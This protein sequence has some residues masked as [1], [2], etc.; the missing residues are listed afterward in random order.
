MA[1]Q[2]AMRQNN[3]KTTIHAKI[4]SQENRIEFH[5]INDGTH[6]IWIHADFEFESLLSDRAFEEIDLNNIK[7]TNANIFSVGELFIDP[8]RNKL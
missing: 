4:N 3:S 8:D 1:R 5:I 2:K 7:I 6:G